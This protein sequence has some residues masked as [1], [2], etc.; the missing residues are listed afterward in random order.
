MQKSGVLVPFLVSVTKIPD[1]NNGGSRFLRVQS[2]M[3]VKAGWAVGAHSHGSCGP[4]KRETWTGTGGVTFKTRS[5]VVHFLQPEPPKALPPAGDQMF[6]H[7]SL[8]SG[9]RRGLQGTGPPGPY[10]PWRPAGSLL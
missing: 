9:H 6:R 2:I 8:A 5:L 7:M 3:V 4:E 10:Q 1:R